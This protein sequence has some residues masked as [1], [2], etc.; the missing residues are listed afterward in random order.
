MNFTIKSSP[1]D[2]SEVSLIPMEEIKTFFRIKLKNIEKVYEY[3]DYR[4]LCCKQLT[5]CSYLV[6]LKSL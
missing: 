2:Y 5:F 1:K 4:T 6:G 3:A